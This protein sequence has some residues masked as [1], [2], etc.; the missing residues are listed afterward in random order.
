MQGTVLYGPRDIRFEDREIPRIE[1][2]T[3]R[4]ANQPPSIRWHA[5]S[6]LVAGTTEAPAAPGECST[7]SAHPALQ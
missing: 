6:A 2:P 5:T 7:D 1:K 4:K 3:D